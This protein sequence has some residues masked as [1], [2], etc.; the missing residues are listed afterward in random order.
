MA[1]FFSIFAVMTFWEWPA[2]RRYAIR[3]FWALAE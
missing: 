1:V 2:P 3:L